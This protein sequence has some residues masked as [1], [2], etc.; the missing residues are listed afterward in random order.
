MRQY[1][2]G[3]LR[4]PPLVQCLAALEAAGFWRLSPLVQR[5]AALEAAGGWRLPPLKLRRSEAD[6]GSEL[7]QENAFYTD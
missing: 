2:A 5:L 4:P 1:V 6:G 7:R 3:G